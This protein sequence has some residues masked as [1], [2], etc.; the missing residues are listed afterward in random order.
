M[1]SRPPF[2]TGAQRLRLLYSLP[3]TSRDTAILVIGCAA[4]ADAAF[5]R[6]ALDVKVDIVSPGSA[7]AESAFDVV[8]LPGCLTHGDRGPAPAASPDGLL[9]AAH[10]ALRP[11]GAIVGHLDHLLS[12]H[13]VR[14]TLQGRASPGNWYRC[15]SVASAARMVRTLLR[16]G[17]AAPQCF[18]VEPQIAAP[19]AIVP[20]HPKAA[21]NHFLRAIRRTRDEYSLPGYALRMA[22]ARL[23]LGGALQPH[24][25]FWARRQC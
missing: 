5:D 14:Q 22:L 21:R 18:Y 25:F 24:L 7:M 4:D 15:R 10:A 23:R 2:A 9:Q 11:G 6:T 20:V 8:A 17:F 12:A 19:M 13:G 1:D 16:A 3:L